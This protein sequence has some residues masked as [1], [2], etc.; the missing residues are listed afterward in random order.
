MEFTT[1]AATEY[2]ST[3][4]PLGTDFYDTI[5]DASCQLTTCNDT[6]WHV[7]SQH[8][9]LRLDVSPDVQLATSAMATHEPQGKP[10][11][12]EVTSECHAAIPLQEFKPFQGAEDIAERQD[13]VSPVV[14]VAAS[15]PDLPPIDK[16]GFLT[17]L[18]QHVS[19]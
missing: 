11:T 15:V 10:D 3:Y 2:R 12:V 9:R 1:Q 17:L 6:L 7:F 4:V 13:T 19:R 14:Q 16:R 18:L 8:Q 5:L